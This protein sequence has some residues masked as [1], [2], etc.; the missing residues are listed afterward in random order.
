M[1]VPIRFTMH[2]ETALR[3][4][5]IKQ[6]WV[7]RVL[8]APKRREPDPLIPQRSRAFGRIEEFGDRWLRVVYETEE[9][10]V[11]VVTAFFDRNAERST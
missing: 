2:A 11:T 10:T 8:E 4:R 3:E 6:E 7:L 9:D 5:D 1:A